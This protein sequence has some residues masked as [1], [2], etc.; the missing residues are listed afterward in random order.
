MLWLMDCGGKQ[1]LVHPPSYAGTHGSLPFLGVAFPRNG[2][3]REKMIG[4]A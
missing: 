4:P 1:I 3:A 2:L